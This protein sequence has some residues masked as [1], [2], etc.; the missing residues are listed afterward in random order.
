MDRVNFKEEYISQIP[1]LQ[2]LMNMGYQYLTPLQAKDARGNRLADVVLTDILRE[3]LHARNAID[4]RGQSVAF[5]DKNIDLAIDELTNLDLSRGL[6]PE[7]ERLYELLTLGTSLEQ[8]I[9]G[10][11]RSY[12]LNFIDWQHPENNVYHITDEYSVTRRAHSDTRRPDIVLFVN[13][14]PLVIIECKRPDKSAQHGGK[15]TF[16]GIQ[17]MIRNQNTDEIPHLFA[18]SQVL[19]SI[20]NTDAKYATTYTPEKFWQ[21]W[22]EEADIEPV[23]HQHINA[24]LS[25]ADK[26]HLY[27]HRE[28][29]KYVRR[30]FDEQ[31]AQP[32][33]PNMQDKTLYAMLR[34]TRLLKLIYQFLVFDAGKKKICRYQQFFAIEATIDRVA[35][36]Q[37]QQRE[38]GVIWHTTGSGK[39]LTM[40]MLSKALALHPSIP[41][42]RVILV[43]DRINL[44]GQIYKTFNACG[45]KAA[46]AKSGKDLGDLIED[47]STDIITTVIDKF[48]TAAREGVRNDS[49]DVFVLVDESHRSQ[50]GTSH[51][52]MKQVFKNACYIG[53]TGTPLL[54]KEKGTAARFGGFIHKYTMRQAVDDGAVVPLLYEGR[55][56]DLDIN[57]NSLDTWF[58]RR[59][60]NLSDEQK[61][62]LKQKM[63]RADEVGRVDQRLMTIAWD[64]AEHYKNNWRGTGFKAQL[65]TSSKQVAIRYRHYLREEDINCEVVISA[66][67]TREGNTEVGESNIPE[68]ERFWK[69]M[70]AQH[71]GEDSYNRHIQDSFANADGTEIIIVVDKLLVGFD[72]PRNTVLY[73]DKQL[74]EHNLLQAIARVNRLFE[75]KPFGYIVDYRGVLGE[76]NEAMETYNALEGFDIEDVAGTVTDIAEI[77][78][79]LPQ[80]HEQLWAFFNPVENPTDLQHL[81]VFLEPEDR[82]DE[83]YDL[84]NAFASTLKVAFGSEVFYEETS[85]SLINRYKRDLKYFH[86]VRQS[87]KQVYAETI[88]YKEYED[89]IRKLMDKHISAKGVTQI[90]NLVNIFDVEE[91]DAEVAHVI[92]ENTKADMILHRLKKTALE[93][94]DKDPAFYRKFSQMI[95]ETLQA[96]REGRISEAEKFRQA[97]ELLAHMRE[98]QDTSLPDSLRQHPHAPAYFGE[99]QD[100]CT[101]IDVDVQDEQLALLSIECEDLI[102]SRKIRDWVTNSYV[103]A[104]MK[105]DLEDCLFDF[106]RANK[107]TLSNG[108]IDT[109]IDNLVGIAIQRND[110]A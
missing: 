88:D 36:V 42:P 85:E 108:S 13:G 96:Y 71:G 97:A 25:E 55:I 75:G 21:I 69:D 39:S 72:E 34:P 83:F 54:K 60:Q 110:M 77:L 104:Q 100:I 65:A 28:R 74:K 78:E 16:A 109:I 94:M 27:S 41:N 47:S 29:A 98:G 68:I 4:Y 91:F 62:D 82:R 93:N 105:N 84:L 87:V 106:Q 90:T 35:H 86:Q 1:A 14:I 64:I 40:V 53:F 7:N 79:Q 99:L 73:I 38:G 51:A 12:S 43:T 10:N 89:K 20:A 44:D 37:G 3:W 9:D 45:K 8:T 101:N 15:A 23:V 66:P 17:Q 5:T 92:G 48:E 63:S 49:A 30:Y 103:Q 11:R 102:E 59:T 61:A 18:Y 67:D 32:R 52:K 31:A 19:L 80:N 26:A 56:V 2:L 24:P 95:E 58:D 107:L 81:I 76:L 50:Y 57:R 22:Q 6:L 33:L 70:M 46:Q